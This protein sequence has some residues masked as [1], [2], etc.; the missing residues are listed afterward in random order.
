M[1]RKVTKEQRHDLRAYDDHD[2]V[3]PY[4]VREF[5]D[6]LDAADDEIERLTKALAESERRAK[7]SESELKRLKARFRLLGEFSAKIN[8]ATTRD[9]IGRLKGEYKAKLEA[10]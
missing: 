8:A 5:L 1:E 3:Y 4:E 9:E 2:V 7:K 10:L 6:D